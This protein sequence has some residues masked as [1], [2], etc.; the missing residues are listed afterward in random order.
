MAKGRGGRAGVTGPYW[1]PAVG[2]GLRSAPRHSGTLEG[3]GVIAVQRVT[4]LPTARHEYPRSMRMNKEYWAMC[5]WD[6]G[7]RGSGL[8]FKSQGMGLRVRG[9]GF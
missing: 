5:W 8:W 9:E 6:V 3:I 7:F 4:L 1:F 2:G